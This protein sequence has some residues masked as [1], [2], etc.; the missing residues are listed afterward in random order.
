MGLAYFLLASAIASSV[1][2]G[3]LIRL[4]G[5]G[6]IRKFRPT[7]RLAHEGPQLKP[8]KGRVGLNLLVAGFMLLA[9]AITVCT[10]G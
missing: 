1:A 6:R 7:H 5:I 3:R 4:H 9:L 2:G 8:G 10:A